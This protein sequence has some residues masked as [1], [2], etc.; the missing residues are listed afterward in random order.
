MEYYKVVA[1]IDGLISK[2]ET[3]EVIS[4]LLDIISKD[5]AYENY[6]FKIT[7][8]IKFFHP[9]K[10][11]GYFK[12]DD[13]SFY[14]IP[15]WN[16]LPYLERVSEQVNKKENKKYIAELLNIIHSVTEYHIN[17]DRSLDNYRTWAYFTRILCNLPS[18]SILLETVELIREW[19]TSK[20]DTS[21]P[22]TEIVKKLLPKFLNS[23]DPEDWKKA[24]K[25]IEIITDID[26]KA[27]SESQHVESETEQEPKTLLSDYW[28]LVAF[29]DNAEK[30]GEKCSEDIVLRLADRLKTVLH[31]RR[32]DSSLDNDYSQIWLKSLWIDNKLVSY[33]TKQTLTII[34]R[35]VLKAKAKTNSDETG[36]IINKFLS[37]E[38]PYSIFKRMVFFVIGCEWDSYKEFFLDMLNS[39]KAREFFSN[40]NY[41]PEIH[42]LL[43]NN[44]GKFTKEEKEKI[45]ATIDQGPLKPLREPLPEK[46]IAYWKQEMFSALKSD[47]YFKS[48][49]DEQRKISQVDEDLFFLKDSEVITG[50]GSSPLSKEEILKMPNKELAYFLKTFRTEDIFRGPT[51]GGLAEFMKEAAQDKPEKI[52]K[53]YEPFMSVGYVYINWILWGVKDAWNQ[54]KIIDW[55]ELFQFIKAYVDRDEFWNNSFTIQDR[56]WSETNADYERVVEATAELIQS[57]TKNDSRVMPGECFDDAQEIIFLFLDRLE[58]RQE[59]GSKDFVSDALNSPFGKAIEAFIYLVYRKTKVI[60]GQ[61]ADKVRQWKAEIT[62]KY[63]EILE[64]RILEGYTFLGQYMP[65]LYLFDDGWI[66]SKVEDFEE[67]KGTEFIEAFMDGYLSAGKVYDEL[68]KLMRPY[69]LYYINYKFGEHSTKDRLVQHISIGYLRGHEGID[70]TDSLF[71]R[72]LDRWDQDQL[73]EI[74]QFFWMQRNYLKP[75]VPKDKEIKE[76][77]LSFWKW[78]YDNKYKKKLELTEED[79]NILAHL[80]ELTIFLDKIDEENFDRIMLSARYVH[81]GFTSPFFIEYL[82]RFEDQES[83]IKTGKIFLEM[84]S[85]FTPDFDQK[86]IRSIVEK[87]YKA[88][89]I[90]NAG[91]ICNIYGSRGCDFLRD[92]YKKNNP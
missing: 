20:F 86:H 35:D 62:G 54:N 8:S 4:K 29:K 38:Y 47:P 83:I 18:E 23:A 71:R 88:R 46:H 78:V 80:A 73:L 14:E 64:K 67:M 1:E 28:L 36:K 2:R 92:I 37:N 61:G 53:D 27:L 52:L 77:I 45:K 39:E 21:F 65:T 5:K 16:V 48:C 44:V 69:Y 3:R 85:V 19:L 87:L 22:G 30:V 40:P 59:Q 68:Y 43:K 12:V 24:E 10:E 79:K 6:F 34:L 84:L 15:E 76:K 63:N 89:E 25:I 91:K 32:N 13:N 9:L 74:I 57:G 66:K 50:A 56:A 31:S 82:D 11:K 55:G 81:V 7:N 49:Y 51:A 17:H 41:K 42:M 90:D 72:L 58:V 26:G 60:E 75:S 33:S 70:D